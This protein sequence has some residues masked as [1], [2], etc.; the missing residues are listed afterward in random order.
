MEAVQNI[1]NIIV[2][3]HENVERKTYWIVVRCKL[4]NGGQRTEIQFKNI[5]FSIWYLF[6]YRFLN[7]SATFNIPNS[8][9]YMYST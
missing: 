8:H 3:L 2:N 1:L 6:H 9:N 7:I 4:P 5:K